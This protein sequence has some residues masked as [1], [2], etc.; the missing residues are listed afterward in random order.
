MNNPNEKTHHGHFYHILL[1]IIFVS[2]WILDSFVF[3]FS[4]FLIDF[5]PLVLRII[6]FAIILGVAFYLWGAAHKALF[7]KIFNPE[8]HR[9]KDLVTTGAFAYIRH[10][11]YLGN[12]L[13]LLS[14]FFLTISLLSLACW[15][16]IFIIFD[17]QA[18]R[19]DQQL[20][21]TYGE[22][23]SN[24]KKSVAKWLPKLKK[25]ENE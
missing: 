11:M 3:K 20:E 25:Y 19:E 2:I 15:V 23:Y 10:P 13:A 4:T 18:A 22:R 21:E 1:P 14:V 5:I 6:L 12:L 9:P 17:R 8:W 7:G 24:Y 16:I